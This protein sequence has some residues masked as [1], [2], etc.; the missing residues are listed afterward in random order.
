MRPIV[1]CA[2]VAPLYHPSTEVP[3]TLHCVDSVGTIVHRPVFKSLQ[4]FLHAISDLNKFWKHC[5]ARDEIGY[6]LMLNETLGA[7]S[8]VIFATRTCYFAMRQREFSWVGYAQLS[9]WHPRLSCSW[10]ERGA[11]VAQTVSRGSLDTNYFRCP[12][13]SRLWIATSSR[14]FNVFCKQ[15]RRNLS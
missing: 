2:N 11:V 15:S 10:E 8:T 9:F 7:V 13:T 3:I 5:K 4:W 12:K 1:S 6:F 14:D